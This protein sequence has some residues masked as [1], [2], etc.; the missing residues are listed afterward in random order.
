[1]ENIAK[2][3]SCIGKPQRKDSTASNIS[4]S[5]APQKHSRASIA[6][7]MTKMGPPEDSAKLDDTQ[8]VPSQTPKPFLKNCVQ[9]GKDFEDSSNTNFH[10]QSTNLSATSG[11]LSRLK[12]NSVQQMPINDK[13]FQSEIPT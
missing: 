11:A 12:G 8:K 3:F 10:R 5:T 7:P 6:H 9:C 1:M 13:S 2:L 4:E